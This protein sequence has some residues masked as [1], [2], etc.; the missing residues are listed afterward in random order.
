LQ[1]ASVSPDG[2]AFVLKFNIP[3]SEVNGLIMRKLTETNEKGPKPEGNAFSKP[4]NN[5]AEK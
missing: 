1:K 4:S 2:K 3:K 5:T